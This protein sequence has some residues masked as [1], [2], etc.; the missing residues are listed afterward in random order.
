M[1]TLVEAST[2][3]LEE[4]RRNYPADD[5]FMITAIIGQNND[6]IHIQICHADQTVKDWCED[7]GGQLRN[8]YH[9]FIKKRLPE[10]YMFKVICFFMLQN[11]TPIGNNANYIAGKIQ[12]HTKDLPRQAHAWMYDTI[13]NQEFGAKLPPCPP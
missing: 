8:L 3:L 7:P 4:A 9:L 10:S 2:K 12:E 5:K 6:Q 11:S 1:P 13:T